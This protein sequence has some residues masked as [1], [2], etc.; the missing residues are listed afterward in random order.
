MLVSLNYY[1]FLAS[2]HPVGFHIPH[3]IISLVGSSLQMCFQDVWIL[4]S[5][6]SFYTRFSKNCR[7]Y[8]L[9]ITT[10]LKTVAWCRQGHAPCKIFLLQQILCLC[11]V[12]FLRSH[13]CRN[14]EM[15]LAT[16]SFLGLKQWC[17]VQWKWVDYH[18]NIEM[19]LATISFLWFKT[20][21]SGSMEVGGLPLQH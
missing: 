7:G 11:Q 8:G 16:I 12:N 17:L 15:N 10:C 6:A 19:N 9:N 5:R 3:F 14:I 13:N 1:Q 2:L 4:P 18:Y 20:V 21:V